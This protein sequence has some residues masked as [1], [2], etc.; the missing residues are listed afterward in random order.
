VRGGGDGSRAVACPHPPLPLPE[1]K[2]TT[3]V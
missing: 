1:G 2:L 3:T